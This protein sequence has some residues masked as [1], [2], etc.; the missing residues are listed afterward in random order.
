[1]RKGQ[2]DW[3]PPMLATLTK[4]VFS[5][6]DWI[7]EPK[8]DGIRCL[9]FKKGHKLRLLSRNQLD[10]TSSYPAIPK[11][12]AKIDG[13]FI[14]D[15]EI[16]AMDNDRT[17]FSMLQQARRQEVPVTYFIFDLIHARGWDLRGLDVLAR[18]AV[19]AK[20]VG[21]RRPLQVVDHIRGEGKD[22]YE[23][24]CKRGW[25]GLIAKRAAAPYVGGR[26]RDWLKFKCS[27]EQE[28]VI[29]G[30]TDPQ[31]ERSGFGALLVGYHEE[32]EL[33]Y[34]GKVGTGFSSKTLTELLSKLKS[35]EQTTSPFSGP[36][37]IRKGAHWVKPRLVA[38]IAF[39]EWTTD[40]KL[41]HPRFLGLR[42]DK[43]AREVVREQ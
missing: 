3:I 4:D 17:S 19:L 15:G 9:A 25:E 41:R 16:A 26:S 43:K 36:P 28:L 38:Q 2:P 37:P 18:K 20:L 23:A 10:L 5:S 42:S 8:L 33:R 7:Y 13:P 34:A 22:Y 21:S 32:N 1:M 14:V 29:G 35:L 6:D 24:A 39:S 11:A 40:G 27:F 30:F 31:G 12:L